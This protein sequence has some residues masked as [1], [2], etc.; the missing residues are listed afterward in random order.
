MKKAAVK[1]SDHTPNTYLLSTSLASCNPKIGFKRFV[2]H[3][4][5]NNNPLS[6]PYKENALRH[7]LQSLALIL[8]ERPFVS[9]K[10]GALKISGFF[11]F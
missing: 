10:L 9:G 4:I 3:I 1:K 8:L 2:P 11:P 5:R 6:T 7:S